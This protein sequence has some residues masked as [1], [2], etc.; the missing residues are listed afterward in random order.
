MGK[1][2]SDEVDRS[3]MVG[4]NLNSS[5]KTLLSTNVHLY[6]PSLIFTQTFATHELIDRY[7]FFY[8]KGRVVLAIQ[9]KVHESY[10]E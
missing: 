5:S 10:S 6:R 9:I 7:P 4:A 1:F 8:K 2:I 3:I